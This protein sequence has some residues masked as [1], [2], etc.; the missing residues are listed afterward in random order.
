MGE[1]PGEPLG[2][3]FSTP[4]PHFLFCLPRLGQHRA[5]DPLSLCDKATAT[6]SSPRQKLCCP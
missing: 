1:W 5:M 2:S 4:L 3:V 6:R